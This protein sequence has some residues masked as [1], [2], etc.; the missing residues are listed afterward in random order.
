[1]S[2]RFILIAAALAAPHLASAGIPAWCGSHEGHYSSGRTALDP[3]PEQAV[4]GIIEGRCSKNAY[5]ESGGPSEA[6]LEKARTTWSQRLLMTEDDWA[7]AVAWS[8]NNEL[9]RDLSTKDL[10]SLTPVDQLRLFRDSFRPASEM[11]LA[12]VLE[13]RLSE[14]GRLGLLISCVGEKAAPSDR[15]KVGAWALCQGDMN[16]FDFKKLSDQLHADTAHAGAARFWARLHGYAMTQRIAEIRAAEKKLV[17]GDAE[18]QK[19]FDTANAARAEWATTV[20]KNQELLALALS[21]D[22]GVLMSSRKQLDGCEAKTT[23]ALAAAVATLPAKAFVGMH[24]QRDDPKTGFVHAVGPL[25]ANTPITS[26]ALIA[27]LE[28]QKTTDAAKALGYFAGSV[29]GYRGPRSAAASA[30]LAADFKFDDPKTN[31]VIDSGGHRPY[32]DFIDATRSAGGVV[33][34]IHKNGDTITVEIQKTKI[35]QEEC[36]AEHDSNRIAEI[37][38]GKVHYQRICD[39]TAM[40][41]HDTTW[42]DFTLDARY[43][44]TLKPG[45]LFSAAGRDLIAVWP[46]KTAK[47]PTWVLGAAIK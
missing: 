47:S 24:D 3:A 1:M 46:S 32:R 10:A 11:Y 41:T 16:Q 5:H 39:K 25:L 33:K 13:S 21:T 20:G 43:A 29:P 38:D 19:V 15:D 8:E 18:F 27:F 31:L 6:E 37:S 12:D 35:V 36:V 14:A 30:L 40:V 34:A 17:A 42:N 26:V 2:S 22:S 4:T 7:E 23:A 9:G 44:G 45:V 28:C